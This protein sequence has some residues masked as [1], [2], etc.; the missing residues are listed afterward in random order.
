MQN[1]EDVIKTTFHIMQDGKPVSKEV[2][3]TRAK[4]LEYNQRT[5]NRKKWSEMYELIVA[6]KAYIQIVDVGNSN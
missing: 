3:M 5:W 4:F 1:A 2:H 6:E